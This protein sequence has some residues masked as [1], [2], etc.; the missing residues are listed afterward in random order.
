MPSAQE[1]LQ[2]MQE[3]QNERPRRTERPMPEQLQMTTEE[4]FQELIQIRIQ[5]IRVNEN[6]REMFSNGTRVGTWLEHNRHR[7]SDEQKKQLGI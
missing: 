1:A 5:G 4:V 6:S 7:F 2:E 3:Y